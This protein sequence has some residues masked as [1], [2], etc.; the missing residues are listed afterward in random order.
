MP[1]ALV[2]GEGAQDPGR[3]VPRGSVE[4]PCLL[5]LDV[6]SAGRGAGWTVA[7][8]AMLEVEAF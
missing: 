8:P 7:A 6:R 3:A 1:K 4:V 5:V 2:G